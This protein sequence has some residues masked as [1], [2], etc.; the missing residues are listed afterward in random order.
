MKKFRITALALMALVA[1]VS[2]TGCSTLFGDENQ[3]TVVTDPAAELVGK[4]VATEEDTTTYQGVS[5]TESGTFTFNYPKKGEKVALSIDGTMKTT[6][7]YPFPDDEIAEAK[8]ME[9]SADL[10]GVK[11]TVTV[12][13]S[14]D[15]K[16]VT[17]KM[18]YSM[19]LTPSKALDYISEM[20]G[21][22]FSVQINGKKNAFRLIVGDDEENALVFK[23]SK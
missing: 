3:W 11:T 14:T 20:M 8:A 9:I 2:F 19:S 12:D 16:T 18:S 23:K 4:W 13:V 15:K 10:N 21:E 6:S 17:I 7:D 22:E 5:H 1:F